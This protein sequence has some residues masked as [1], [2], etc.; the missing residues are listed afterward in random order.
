MESGIL[1]PNTYSQELWEKSKVKDHK[2]YIG[3]PY[4]SW[5]Q[6]E[7]FN[8]SKGFNTGLNGSYE[9]MLKYFS[10]EKWPDMGW[11]QFG[12][13]AEAYITLRGKNTDKLDTYDAE[14]LK[15][16]INNF[17]DDEKEVLERIKPLGV[18]QDEICYYVEELDIIV[19]GYIDDRNR[20]RNGVIKNLRDYKTKSQSSK[21]DLHL[22]KKYQ[23]ELYTLGLRQRGLEV[24]SAEYC[25]IER[26]GGRECMQGGGR[27]V[28]KVGNNVWYEPYKN[29]TEDRLAKTHE[30]IVST[31]KEISS[32]YKTYTKFFKDVEA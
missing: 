1:L 23:I 26:L 31:A 5:S 8:D 3:K 25:I 14:C 27:E 19:L 17:N 28:L 18:F 13:E 21:K 15:S 12:S 20:P 4:L 9:Y 6:I 32:L 2:K 11:A 29:L 30:M 10:G 16:A 7:S 22:P 24:E